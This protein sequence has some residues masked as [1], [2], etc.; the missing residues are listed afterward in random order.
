MKINLQYFQRNKKIGIYTK[1]LKFMA[2][3]FV[4]SLVI[5]SSSSAFAVDTIPS[6]ATEELEHHE[7][8]RKSIL[9]LYNDPLS[10]ISETIDLN[11][12][13]VGN[14]I[15]VY[16]YEEAGMVESNTAAYSLCSDNTLCA[17]A[18]VTDGLAQIDSQIANEILNS[19]IAGNN[20]SF[21]YDAEGM[22][23]FDGTNYYLLHTYE[24]VEDREVLENTNEGIS[25]QNELS[26]SADYLQTI[27]LDISASASAASVTA[28]T[29]YLNVGF[30]SQ[31]SGSNYCW[32]CADTCIGNYV[33]GVYRSPYSFASLC[34]PSNP[35]SSMN[36][37]DAIYWLNYYYS[38]P[39]SYVVYGDIPSID[40]IKYFLDYDYPIYGQFAY[41]ESYNSRHATV[42]RGAD[43]YNGYISLMDPDT[44]S[45]YRSATM[46]WIGSQLTFK[47]TYSSNNT[48][49]ILTNS[50]YPN[51]WG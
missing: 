13:E 6:N 25:V 46:T 37:D 50:A 43:T 32:A 27:P 45:Y 4:M 39:Y 48:T 23:V 22:Y 11:N 29:V 3:I 19:D 35:N 10:D 42:I 47:Y 21:L 28:S 14:K 2:L 18:F 16:N 40:Q 26:I 7:I 38:M 41:S 24:T 31:P 17:I 15:P 44:S 51:F 36:I 20:I 49:W 8:I 34:N 9:F 33:T 12:V 5:S 30:F 1:K